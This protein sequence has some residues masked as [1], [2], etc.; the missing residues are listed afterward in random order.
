MLYFSLYA[1]FLTYFFPFCTCSFIDDALSDGVPVMM[2]IAYSRNGDKISRSVWPYYCFLLI[3]ISWFEI[4]FFLDMVLILFELSKIEQ[5]KLTALELN[6]ENIWDGSQEYN[7]F[8]EVH[9]NMKV[10]PINAHS[11]GS[12]VQSKWFKLHYIL[13]L[14]NHDS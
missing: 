12:L 13:T 9:R 14:E 6:F 8:V 2:L 10:T 5:C 4:F 7:N 11:L 3:W 1:V